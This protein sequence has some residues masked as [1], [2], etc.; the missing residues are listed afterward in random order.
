MIPILQC[1]AVVLMIQSRWFNEESR[2]HLIISDL[3]FTQVLRKIMI[4]VS[5]VGHLLLQNGQYVSRSFRVQ[6]ADHFVCQNSNHFVVPI[7]TKRELSIENPS[8]WIF[9]NLP[10]PM[11]IILHLYKCPST[12]LPWRCKI[13]KEIPADQFRLILPMKLQDLQVSLLLGA[14]LNSAS[15]SL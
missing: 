2:L 1:Y 10:A 14:C 6:A 9:H 13:W 11:L 5:R 15:K 12:N 3:T 4:M 7:S 8:W